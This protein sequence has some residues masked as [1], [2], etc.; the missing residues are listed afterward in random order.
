MKKI[1]KILFSIFVAISLF[2]NIYLID[3]I[4][5]LDFK[6]FYNINV[7]AIAITSILVYNFISKKNVKDVSKLKKALS[8]IFALFMILG[9][10]YASYGS[11][12]LIF[13][14]ITTFI[15]SVIKLCGFS[16]IFTHLFLIL[17]NYI[18]K[19]K[20]KDIKFKNK[21]LSKFMDIFNKYPFRTSFVCI[22]I[23]ICIGMLA[24]YPIVLSPDPSFQI[25]MYFNEHTKYIDWVIQR[26]PNVFMTAHHPVLQTFM[27][28]YAIEIGRHF[29]NDNFGLFIYTFIQ[30]FI[31]ASVLAYTIKFL[32]EHNINSKMRLIVLLIYM[33][34]PMFTLYS[35]S[36]VKDTLY[37]AFMILFT[38]K[39][40]DIVENYKDKQINIKYLIPL[41]FIMLF[42]AL[43]RH[44]GVYVIALT[45]FVLLFYSRKNILRILITFLLFFISIYSFDNIL[46]PSLGI[47]DGSVREMLSVPFQQ[48]ARLVKEKP[49]FYKGEDKKIIDYILKY[50]TLATRYDPNLADPVK[51]K[52]NKETTNADLA[53]YFKAWFKGL[54]KHPDIY[55][56]ATM[57]N[58]YGYFYPNAHKWYVYTEFDE[59]V[60]QNDLVDYHY[61]NLDGLRNVIT[62]YA[63]IFPFIPVIGLISNIAI[64]TWVILILSVYLLVTKNKKYLISLVPLYGSL[65]FCILGPANT[66]FRYAMP[67]IFV[68]PALIMLLL[69]V[70]RGDNREKE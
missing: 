66:Y 47:S 46:V 64:N 23:V 51:N 2:I 4:K 16:Y 5:D 45:I 61:N 8:I 38:L 53:K 32:K 6:V 40:F 56:D 60:T 30:S 28:G 27:I 25:K 62:I 39:V 59:R 57:N 21:Y 37:T 17:D 14:N 49:K 19:I 12:K 26:D 48:T 63:N 11:Y 69:K 58:I 24:F 65:I 52:F 43:F 50:K 42:I 41:Y 13:L 7:L 29:V 70:I 67:Y 18:P 44:N 54:V 68:L 3:N 10:S 15:I 35:L 22:F 9:E 55:V 36:A 34:V 20:D 31:Y 1:S 33:F